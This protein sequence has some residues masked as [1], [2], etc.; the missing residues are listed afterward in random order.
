MYDR[1]PI[2]KTHEKARGGFLRAGLMIS[3]MMSFCS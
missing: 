1:R 3:A 2:Q